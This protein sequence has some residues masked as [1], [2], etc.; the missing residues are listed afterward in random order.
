MGDEVQML[1]FHQD[2]FCHAGL[3]HTCVMVSWENNNG[4]F[5]LQAL[6]QQIFSTQ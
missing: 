1:K 5:N 6:R 4:S 3:Q 2:L